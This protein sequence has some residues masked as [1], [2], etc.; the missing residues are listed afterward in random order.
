MKVG[1]SEDEL[2]V[3]RMDLARGVAEELP[4]FA[5]K[6]RL[7]PG[8]GARICQSSEQLPD[9]AW[10]PVRETDFA[11]RLADARSPPSRVG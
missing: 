7:T 5:H 3:G 1:D 11:A 10:R 2:A 4:A 6:R 8:A 9:E